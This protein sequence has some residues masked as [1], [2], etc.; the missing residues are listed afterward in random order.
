MLWMLKDK[1]EKNY[2]KFLENKNYE[3]QKWNKSSKSKAE[4]LDKLEIKN[5][6]IEI[7]HSKDGVNFGTKKIV[8]WKILLRFSPGSQ[9]RE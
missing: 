5:L 9:H 4:W 7:K 2:I 8:N 1:N 3:K 6:L